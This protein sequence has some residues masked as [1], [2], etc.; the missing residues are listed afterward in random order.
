MW[1][2]CV[3]FCRRYFYFIFCNFKKT[4]LNEYQK[5]FYSYLQSPMSIEG[6]TVTNP[7]SRGA[8]SHLQYLQFLKMCTLWL[9][10]APGPRME[11]ISQWSE[12]LKLT[13]CHLEKDQRD[14]NAVYT[15]VVFIKPLKWICLYI[16]LLLSLCSSVALFLSSSVF[17]QLA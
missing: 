12:V 6:Y 13:Y 2:K 15:S 8:Y 1:K 10:L 9:S 4:V 14:R 3:E 16:V 5:I 11:K 7:S 17:I